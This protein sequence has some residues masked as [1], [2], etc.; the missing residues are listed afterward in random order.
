MDKALIQKRRQHQFLQIAP[1]HLGEEAARRAVRIALECMK[2]RGKLD[3]RNGK[4]RLPQ[5]DGGVREV[6]LS[7]R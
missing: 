4:L 2:V 7:D 5:S 6:P 3:W 1:I